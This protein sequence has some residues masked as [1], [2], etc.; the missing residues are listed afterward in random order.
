MVTLA[1][2]SEIQLASHIVKQVVPYNTSSS[3]GTFKVGSPYKIKGK[4]YY[5]KEQYDLVETGIAS[6][7][8]PNFHGKQTANGE[9]FNKRELTAAH[10][11][12]QMPSLIRVTNLQNGR[13]LIVRVN[14]RGPFSRGRILDLSERS[15]ELLGFKKQGTAKIKLEVLPEESR[16]IAMAAKRGK[17]TGGY[18]VAMNQKRSIS[19]EIVRDVS[20]NVTATA[21]P[22]VIASA[23]V[24]G[25]YGSATIKPVRIERL[26]DVPSSAPVKITT[27]I[28]GH[29][30]DGKFYPDPIIE[31]VAIS[32]NDIYI[33]AGAFTVYN[34]ALGLKNRLIAYGSTSI[35]PTNINGTKFYRVRLGPLK[36]V[37]MADAL[38]D[39]VIRGG[40][41]NAIIVVE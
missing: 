11:T 33:Q 29:S 3:K 8:G 36:S 14:D 22:S 17:D 24:S 34:N 10:R 26:A 15:A 31:E 9:I 13:S 4:M 16:Q 18:E 40:N 41:D 2:C 12:L 27:M 1:G 25:D 28:P 5:P 32:S 37:E 39:R 35:Q 19:K 7:Y 38:L 23:S 21:K 6:W 30:V 20:A